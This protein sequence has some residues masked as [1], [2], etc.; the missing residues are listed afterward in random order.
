[1]AKKKEKSLKATKAA[2][3]VGGSA[4]SSNARGLPPYRPFIIVQFSNKKKPTKL[5]LE[6]NEENHILPPTSEYQTM[7][8]R[9]SKTQIVRS[10]RKLPKEMQQQM[11]CAFIQWVDL[12]DRS[13]SMVD[14]CARNLDQFLR[15]SEYLGVGRFEDIDKASLYGFSDFCQKTITHKGF[16]QILDILWTNL[17]LT[18]LA[19]FDFVVSRDVVNKDSDNDNELIAE[20]FG[21]KE[22]SERVLMQLTGYVVY[23]INQIFERLKEYKS[24]THESLEKEGILFSTGAT[25]SRTL[26]DKN[27][28]HYKLW[29]TYQEDKDKALDIVHKNM[30]LA[31]K[32]HQESHKEGQEAFFTPVAFSNW[33]NRISNDLFPIANEYRASFI[34]KYGVALGQGQKIQYS[35][36]CCEKNTFNRFIIK[37]YLLLQTGVN[38]E[39]VNTLTRSYEGRHWTDR[40]DLELGVDAGSKIERQVVRIDGVKGRGKFKKIVSI[41][42][43]VQSHLYKVLEL[44]EDLFSKPEADVFFPGYKHTYHQESKNFLAANP[45]LDGVDELESLDSRR[46]RK[47]FAGVKLAQAIE[48]AKSGHDLTQILRDALDH[49][50]FDTTLFSYLLKTGIGNFAISHA[51]AALTTKMIEDALHFK[52]KIIATDKSDEAITSDSIPVYLCDC[53]DP[54]NPTHGVPISSRCTKYDLC[55]GCERSEVYAEHIPRICYRILQYEATPSP[56]SDLMADR[57]AIALDTLDRFRHEHPDGGHLLE[58]GYGIANQAMLDN[59]PL[60]PPII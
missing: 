9:R 37:T 22:Y 45:I 58:M 46:I 1:M 48:E 49:E 42:V 27:S 30:L 50:D 43:P 23:R 59:K 47:S 52:G 25:G 26:K 32:C 11:A 39:V 19:G 41:R 51:I 5:W 54:T 18:N 31:T 12:N 15:F 55:L 14:V 17:G 4:S 29:R 21:E 56:A 24:V 3:N 53:A 28:F 20:I 33:L 40:F 6:E 16:L 44:A 10:D 2:V 38:L 57:K 35:T 34:E 7:Y 60:L 13:S 8:G 36:F